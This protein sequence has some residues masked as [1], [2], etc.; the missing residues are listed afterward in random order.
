MSR[1]LHSG[2]II[3]S[4]QPGMCVKM[5]ILPDICP[6]SSEKPIERLSG[7]IKCV[8]MTIDYQAAKSWAPLLEMTGV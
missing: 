1:K 2:T 8:Q 4:E 3:D 5:K 7:V 6:K